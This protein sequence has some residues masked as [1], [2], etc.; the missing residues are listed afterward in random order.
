[1]ADPE[2]TNP[3]RARS[4]CHFRL[5]QT[6]KLTES[7]RTNLADLEARVQAVAP[8]LQLPTGSASQTR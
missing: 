5:K 1:M 8:D 6:E 3:R 2:L 7:Y 4:R